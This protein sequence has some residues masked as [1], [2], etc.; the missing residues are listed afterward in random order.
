M[1][2]VI[3]HAQLSAVPAAAVQCPELAAKRPAYLAQVPQGGS[4]NS[5]QR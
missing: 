4:N 3:L 5:V 1:K 2:A